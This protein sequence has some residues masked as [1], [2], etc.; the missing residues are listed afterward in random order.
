[1]TI[2]T[3]SCLI[4]LVSIHGVGPTLSAT[5]HVLGSF[6]VLIAAATRVGLA[7][8]FDVHR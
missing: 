6:P 1:M 4:V 7:V 8:H 2:R 3:R 5:C